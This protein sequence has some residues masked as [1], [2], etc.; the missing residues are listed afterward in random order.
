V[1]NLRRLLVV[2]R[3][4]RRHES[5]AQ[6]E[7][8]DVQKRLHDA[9][10]K[11]EKLRRPTFD[12]QGPNLNPAQLIALRAQG[13]VNAEDLGLA[14]DAWA[15]CEA[16]VRHATR[17]MQSATAKRKASDELISK[18]RLANAAVA[19]KASQAALDELVVLRH[20]MET[21]RS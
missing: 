18:R 9:R 10:R 5:Q 14:R 21:R 20:G 15:K 8:A 13:V 11:L 2:S 1:S 7:L 19:A 6:V 12:A 3:L 17:A 16:E 4:R